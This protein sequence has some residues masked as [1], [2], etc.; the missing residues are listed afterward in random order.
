MAPLTAFIYRRML[1]YIDVMKCCCKD[2]VPGMQLNIN[3]DLTLNEPCIIFYLVFSSFFLLNVRNF[4]LYEKL[5]IFAQ[6][7]K[8]NQVTDNNHQQIWKI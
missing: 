3:E 1:E 7:F 2:V 4:E 5:F 8:E 6:L